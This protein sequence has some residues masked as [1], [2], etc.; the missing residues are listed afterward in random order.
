[1]QAGHARELDEP[2]ELGLNALGSTL[3]ESDFTFGLLIPSQRVGRKRGL[4]Q[5]P[6][7]YRNVSPDDDLVFDHVQIVART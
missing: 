5:Y 4:R 3:S 7:I 6:N 2:S 1:M